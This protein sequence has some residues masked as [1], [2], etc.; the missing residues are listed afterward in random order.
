MFGIFQQFS[1]VKGKQY[2]VPKV[3]C[4][5]AFF[6]MLALLLSYLYLLI[7]ISN[8]Y[9]QSLCEQ[10]FFPSSNDVIFY[11]RLYFRDFSG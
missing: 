1:L 9:L 8:T 10:D 4:T 7:I 11:L 2:F 3:F 6:L 5:Q